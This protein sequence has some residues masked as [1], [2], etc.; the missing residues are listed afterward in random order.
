MPPG[1]PTDPAGH[2]EPASPGCQNVTPV[3][4]RVGD[5]WSV[6][7]VMMLV[8]TA[9]AL[10]RAQARDRRHLAAH[11]DPDPARARARRPGHAHRHPSIPPRV[12]YELTELGASLA[13]RSRRS[14]TGRSPTS[15]ASAPRRPASTR[16]PTPSCDDNSL[17]CRL[18]HHAAVQSRRLGR[19]RGSSVLAQD[20]PISSCSSLTMDQP[21]LVLHLG[22]NRLPSPS[23][24][25]PAAQPGRQCGA[26]PRHL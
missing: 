5:K 11:A 10:Q 25:S 26:Q 4:N 21:P 19:G 1:T 17:P 18:G 24:D 15:P 3:L 16:S 14:A 6:L 2:D 9:H 20:F 23:V 13:S 7:I 22:A 12:D 8:A